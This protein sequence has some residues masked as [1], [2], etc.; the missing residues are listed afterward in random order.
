MHVYRIV[1]EKKRTGD[2]SGTG[3]YRRGGR[4][5]NKGTYMIYTSEN[6]SLAYLENLVYFDEFDAPARP[7]IIKLSISGS[8]P[9][10]TLP[11]A[12]YPRNWQKVGYLACKK[13]GDDFIADNKYLALKVRSAVNPAEFNYLLNPL[14]PGFHRLVEIQSVQSIKVDQ[15]FVKMGR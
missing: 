5:N 11:D 6:S 13:I 8:S 3:A 1:K 14:F 10:Y 2:L 7:Y 15:R 9:I 4:W 12:Q